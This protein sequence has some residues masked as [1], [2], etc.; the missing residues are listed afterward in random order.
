MGFLRGGGFLVKSVSGHTVCFPRWLWLRLVHMG[1]GALKL[2][3]IDENDVLI[4]YTAAA[5]VAI[6]N[7]DVILPFVYY[8]CTVHF[9]KILVNRAYF[10]CC[11]N[12]R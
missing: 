9:C 10:C 1:D 4:Y 8:Y 3:S 11:S 7:H 6:L 12:N 2:L 5:I